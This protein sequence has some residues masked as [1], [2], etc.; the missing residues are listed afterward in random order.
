MEN[1]IKYNLA[2]AFPKAE[3]WT[4]QIEEGFSRPAFFVQRIESDY[5]QEVGNRYLHHVSFAVHYF[6]DQ[7]SRGQNEDF[8]DMVMKLWAVL[9]EISYQGEVLHGY[10]MSQR[11]DDEVLQFFVTY[12]RYIAAPNMTE[13]TKMQTMNYEIETEE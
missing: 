6:T 8:A 11:T 13:E 9:R 4:E 10:D 3:I 5:L 2:Q 1:I 7:P 12:R